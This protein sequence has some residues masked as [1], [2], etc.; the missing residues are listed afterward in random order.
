MSKDI[1]RFTQ[2]LNYIENHLF[3]EIEL[4]ALAKQALLSE[5]TF[6]RF[7]TYLTGYSFSNY[8]RNRR[9][10]QAVDYLRNE[11]ASINDLSEMCGYANR[12]A[13]NRAFTKF[14]GLTLTEA[15]DPQAMVNFFPP[16][17]L[18]LQIDG[19]KTLNYRVETLPAFSVIGTIQEYQLNDQLFDQTC[20]HWGTF[21]QNHKLR[22]F[23]ESGK[24]ITN[25]FG[26]NREPYFAV[27]NPRRP[28]SGKLAYF[29]GFAIEQSS[30]EYDRFDLPAQ[31]YAV[32]TS[33]PYVYREP[34]NVSKAFNQL[35]QQ[36]FNSWLP[37]TD[38]VKVD[39]PELE[40]YV[41]V[42]D[43]ACLEIWLPVERN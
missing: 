8:V 29:T 38:Y 28:E 13:F 27:A 2:T 7:F 43:H 10:S 11:Q 42:G 3:E 19:G 16:I 39:G 5:Y 22:K 24:V 6:H 9:L 33:E 25:F 4:K 30:A 26:V 35:Q 40:T 23:A 34:S 20:Q 17:R 14:H 18:N 21:F 12:P 31:T 36:I 41:A 37:Q 1:E 32:F 15:K